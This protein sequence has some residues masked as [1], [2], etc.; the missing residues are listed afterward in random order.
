MGTNNQEAW[1]AILEERNT[2]ARQLADMTDERD[3]LILERDTALAEAARLSNW[4]DQIMTEPPPG[5]V[6][7]GELADVEGEAE[8]Y[9]AYEG[10]PM[11]ERLKPGKGRSTAGSFRG[12]YAAG[13]AEGGLK[14]PPSN[15]TRRMPLPPLEGPLAG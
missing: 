10:L 7:F 12:G 15:V 5:W 2:W 1:D 3:A 11:W 8:L 14:P 9:G 4:R 6:V 13:R